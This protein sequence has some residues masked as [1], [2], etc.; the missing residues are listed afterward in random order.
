[1]DSMRSRT[2][3]PTH[4]GEILREEYLKPLAMSAGILAKH[5]N[6]P[7]TR[8]ERLAAEETAVTPDTALRLARF[9]ST[10][11]DFWMAM[12]TGY[13]LAIAQAEKADALSAIT[14]MQAA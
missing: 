7:R 1:M 13:D 14:P 5:L 11:A 3:K 8:I 10:T 2:R 9:F 4:P 12:Q 6:V